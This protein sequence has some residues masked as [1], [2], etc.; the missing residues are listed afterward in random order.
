MLSL[1]LLLVV[2][3]RPSSTQSVMPFQQI[4]SNVK[5]QL[6]RKPLLIHGIIG[7]ILFGGSD[8]FAQKIELAQQEQALRRK[9]Q[10]SKTDDENVLSLIKWSIDDIDTRRFLTAATIGALFGGF[11]YPNAYKQLDKLWKDS[12]LSSIVKKSIVE[13]FTVG[14]F[15]NSVSMGA[16]GLLVGHEPNHVVSHVMKEMPHVTFNDFKVWFP[17]NMLLFSAIPV[18]VRPA[19]TSLMEAL[20]QT[21]ISLRSNDYIADDDATCAVTKNDAPLNFLNPIKT[22]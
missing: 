10:R 6:Q 11:V 5:V 19:T 18:Y 14:I 8:V 22:S 21:Y 2:I 15:A 17:Y 1:I 3:Q 9:L 13:I 20:W 4:L 7:S 12:D 16:R